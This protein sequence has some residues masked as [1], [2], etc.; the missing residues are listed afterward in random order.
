MTNKVQVEVAGM[1]STA[2]DLDGVASALDTVKAALDTAVQAYNGCWG[3]DEYGRQFTDGDGGYTK[4]QPV[5]ETTI[6]SV[7]D[8]LRQYSSGLRQG[9]NTFDQTEQ[10]NADG[11]K[12]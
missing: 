12:S 11:F 6:T 2:T 3:A 9:A 5:L 10:V 7:A 1:R 8:R 4:R